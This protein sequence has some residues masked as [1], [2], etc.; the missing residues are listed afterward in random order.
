MKQLTLLAALFAF[1]GAAHAQNPYFD[2]LRSDIRAEKEGIVREVMQLNNEESTTFWPVYRNYEH[3]LTQ[4]NDQKLLLIVDYADSYESMTDRM[5][6][7]LMQRAFKL[8]QD[9]IKL[10]KQFFD[11]MKR[12]VST[13]TAV[14]FFQLEHQLGL[15]VDLQIVSELPFIK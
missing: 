3:E 8:Q 5:A 10:R 13:T 15:I 9:R 4:L 7:D 11:L 6:E 2:L 12:E 14:K 1:G